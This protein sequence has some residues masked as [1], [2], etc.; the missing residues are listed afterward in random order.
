[1]MARVAEW[2]GIAAGVGLFVAGIAVASSSASDQPD[3]IA[4]A[5]LTDPL[6]VRDVS[7][8]PV[9]VTGR[10]VDAAG[11]PV[12]GVEV[13]VY[14][15]S[16]LD[17]ANKQRAVTGADGR[18]AMRNLAPGRYTFVAL[19]GQQPSGAREN[20]AVFAEPDDLEI[21]LDQA[22]IDA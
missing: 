11:T 8:Q 14:R 7:A 20:V 22:P 3:R 12:S 9:C 10:V 19:H 4:A 6:F 18:F 17:P 21:V 16:N 15:R 13:L 2:A 5:R 1:M